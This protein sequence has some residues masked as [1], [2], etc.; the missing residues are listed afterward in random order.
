MCD[1]ICNQ[2]Q[3][4]NHN[5]ICPLCEAERDERDRIMEDDEREREWLER[6]LADEDDDHFDP[7]PEPDFDAYSDGMGDFESMQTDEEAWDEWRQ[8][9][10]RLWQEWSDAEARAWEN[11]N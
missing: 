1:C 6:E 3:Y 5:T 8:E 2:P 10:D 11:W 4:L 9:N 7:G